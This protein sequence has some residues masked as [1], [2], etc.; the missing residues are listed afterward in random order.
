LKIAFLGHGRCGKDT[1]CKYFSILTGI[2][3]AGTTSLYLAEDV[4]KVLG[5]TPE[6]AYRRRHESVEMRKLWKKTGDVV[7]NGDPTLLLRRALAVGPITGGLRSRVE[8]LG[9][10]DEG[11][12]DLLVW[13]ENDRVPPDPT[14][15]F[16]GRDCDLIV[17][18]HG[19]K[20]ELADRLRRLARFG[21]LLKRD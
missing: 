5:T 2:K 8:V 13:V 20:R 9:A 17:P 18:N 11:L 7:R 21:G 1:C 10:R 15:E 19:S 4:A 6:E 12:A 14:V 16:S 3:N